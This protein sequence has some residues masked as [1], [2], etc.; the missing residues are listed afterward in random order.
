MGRL[1][2]RNSE[3]KNVALKLRAEIGRATWRY[4]HAAAAHHP[5][6][7]TAQQQR[8]T[9]AWIASF[10]Q[11]YPCKHCAEHFVGVCERSPPRTA[12]REDY[13]MWW[14]EAHNSVSKDLQ[15][16]LRRC[17]PAQLITAGRAG[18]TLDELTAS[19]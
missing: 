13:A 8:D 12:R 17:Q 19:E 16:D 7:A 1:C 3:P 18:L 14:C 5:D 2:A 6:K 11:L 15:N 9:M 4:L 10:V